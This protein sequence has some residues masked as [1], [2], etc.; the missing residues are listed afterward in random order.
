MTTAGAHM[1]TPKKNAISEPSFSA[2]STASQQGFT[3]IELIM[4]IVIIGI[5]AAFALP[6]FAD[7]GSSARIASL[8]GALSA[9]RSAAYIAHSAQL[10]AGAAAN[11]SV[12]LEGTAITMISA[13]PTANAAGILA[14]AQL[15]S[16]FSITGGGALVT[17]VLTVQVASATTPANCSFTYSAAAA[18]ATPVFSAPLT[19]GC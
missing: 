10:A 15:S 14:A 6:R 13:Y 3:M 16:E 1:L 8:N 9:A 5:L 4:V 2:Q 12:T 7:L 17:S 19:A 18:N 11:A